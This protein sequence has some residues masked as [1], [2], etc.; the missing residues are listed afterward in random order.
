[1]D[2]C[3]IERLLDQGI[4]VPENISRAIP[5]WVFPYGTGSSA[6]HQSHPDVILVRSI[7]GRQAH[8]YPFQIPP[9]DRDIHLVG[10]K[11]CT[12]TNPFIT[13][14]RAAT[15]HS[16]TIT[17]LRTRSSRNPNR[18][19]KVTLHIILFRVAGTIY[20]EYTITPLVNLGLTEQKAKS[21]A[22]KLR[23]HAIQRLNIIINT[24][25]ALCSWGGVLGARRR[26][27]GEGESGHPGAWRATL[28]IPIRY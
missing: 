25:H 11:F 27:T 15:R 21:L 24:K 2:A 5:H 8:L 23:D 1:M 18:N 22:S 4:K 17:R 12:D 9:Q 6:R 13:F 7:P 10:L 3:R 16:H 26:R 28:Q 14:K 20:N 19:N